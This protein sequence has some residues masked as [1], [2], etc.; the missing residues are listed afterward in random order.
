MASTA[1]LKASLQKRLRS[2][3]GN[4]RSRGV[5]AVQVE[6]ILRRLP[7][8]RARLFLVGGLLRDMA[9]SQHSY[10]P[11]D[12]DFMV[13]GVSRAQLSIKYADL[14]SGRTSLGGYRLGEKGLRKM[15]S[16]IWRLEDTW[17]LKQQN[18]EKSIQAF[19]ST[20]FLN[21]DCIVAEWVECDHDWRV[22]DHGFW[23]GA[24]L[25]TLDIN[26]PLNPYPL[27]CAIRSIA[28]SRKYNF[29]VTHRLARFAISEI[30]DVSKDELL[31]VQKSHFGREIFT[32]S[33]VQRISERLNVKLQGRA[34][35]PF[36]VFPLGH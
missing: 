26:Y 22:H 30:E 18:Q 6:S 12:I 1:H 11:R 17:A 7:G 24:S 4:E 36:E 33:Q 16:D 15:T 5:T 10:R 13:A 9:L 29:K 35:R 21:L 2:L 32:F 34:E 27:L 28:L 3:T 20:P 14:I 23:S 19:L 25:R 8:G 31:W